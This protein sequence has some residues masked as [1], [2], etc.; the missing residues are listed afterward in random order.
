M[1]N[2]FISAV[3]RSSGNCLHVLVKNKHEQILRAC[4]LSE[5]DFIQVLNCSVYCLFFYKSSLLALTFEH[6]PLHSLLH[7][8]LIGSSPILTS[9]N[10]SELFKSLENQSFEWSTEVKSGCFIC[11][12]Q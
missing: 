5:L 11:F 4:T 10:Y 8:L 7:H 12:W 1:F 3:T 2:F 6:I 9:G